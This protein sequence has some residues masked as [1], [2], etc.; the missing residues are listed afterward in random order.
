MAVDLFSWS[1]TA[2]SN[3][4]INGIDIDENWAAANINNAIRDMM[5]QLALLRKLISGSITTGGSANAQTL[6]SGFSMSS[7]QQDMPLSF[8]AGF[9]NTATATLDVDSIG[10][11][12][13]NHN[14]QVLLP[15]DILA[16]STYWCTYESDGDVIV[17]HNPS[18][19]RGV[20]GITADTSTAYTLVLA[21]AGK[22]VTMSNASANELT[23]PA[24]SAVAFVIGTIIGIRQKGAGAT[25]VTAD[26]GVTLN[27]TS[28]GSGVLLARYS[29]VS[30]IKE[31]SDAWSIIGAHAAVS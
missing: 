4:D 10:A 30:I 9:T 28:A 15:G 23:I 11:K 6:A 29:G 14:G 25:T 26:T 21:D 17:L 1:T 3:T 16:G 19:Q 22:M 31:G 20:I 8:E 7:Y 2:G 27:G 12:T 5:A 24:N 18:N 13:F